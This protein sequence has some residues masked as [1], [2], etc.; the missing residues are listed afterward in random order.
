M[1]A[2]VFTGVWAILGY[3]VS[4]GTAYLYGRALLGWLRER[5]FSPEPEPEP[6]PPVLLLRRF[7]NRG[8]AGGEG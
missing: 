5:F 1:T 2:S 7:D 6:L 3:S 4:V 8:Q